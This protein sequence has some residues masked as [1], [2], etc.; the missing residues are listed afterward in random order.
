MEKNVKFDRPSGIVASRVVVGTNPPRLPNS[1][2][3]SSR[4]QTHLFIKG[5][6]PTKTVSIPQKSQNDNENITTT[7]PQVLEP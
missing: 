3:P 1:S 5:T 7:L 2:T 6:Q 4:V